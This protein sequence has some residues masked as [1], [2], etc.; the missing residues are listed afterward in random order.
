MKNKQ[1]SD[2]KFILLLLLLATHFAQAQS[3]R[4]YMAAG[5]SLFA[6]KQYT[7]SL[8]QYR[9]VL[10]QKYY[11]PALFLKMAYIFE[12]LGV[13][14]ES[15]YYLSLYHLASHD[16][17]ALKK[18]EEI[19]NSHQL[20]GYKMDDT[21]QLQ[22][23]LQ[24]NYGLLVLALVSAVVFLFALLVYQKRKYGRRPLFTGIALVLLLGGLFLLVN[25]KG[26]TGRG[27][28]R[29]PATYL[30]MGP[31]AGADVL[32]IIGEG[33]QLPITGRED[34]WLKVKWMG[35]DAYLKENEILRIEI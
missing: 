1:K 18:M 24:K 22:H 13:L 4:S 35:R 9:K 14:S 27:I 28:V 31:S 19:A 16:H 3:P 12:G 15:L 34:V 32:E 10:D 20:Q 25:Y 29:Q 5:D 7:E 11:S 23:L 2:L 21:I 8:G 30:M 33:H 17:Q 6:Q 26:K